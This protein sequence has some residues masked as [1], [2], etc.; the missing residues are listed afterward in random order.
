MFILHKIYKTAQF[1]NTCIFLRKIICVTHHSYLA[2][3][4]IRQ[5][6][7]GTQNSFDTEFGDAD[8]VAV[9]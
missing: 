7:R 6:V 4:W 8:L 5:D 2:K 9:K 3:A 1:L